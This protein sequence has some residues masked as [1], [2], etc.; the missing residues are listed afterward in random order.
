MTDISVMEV[1]SDFLHSGF[2]PFDNQPRCSEYENTSQSDQANIMWKILNKSSV[3]GKFNKTGCEMEVVEP[4]LMQMKEFYHGMF[5]L[6][7]WNAL[8]LWLPCWE[9]SMFVVKFKIKVS[10]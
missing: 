1:G 5:I 6:M 3:E 7:R 4:I 10:G 2:S 9:T 8:Q